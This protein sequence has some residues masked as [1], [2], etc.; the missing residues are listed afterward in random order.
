MELKFPNLVIYLIIAIVAS[1]AHRS[2]RISSPEFHGE[3][4][5]ALAKYVISIRSRTPQTFFGD[6]HYCCGGLISPRWALTAAHCVM[7][8]L[9]VM[10]MPR[11]LLVVAGTPQRLRYVHGKTVCTPVESLHVPKEFIMFNQMNMALIRLKNALPMN[12]P[13]IGFLLLPLGPPNYGDIYSVL[14]WG[15]MYMGGPLASEILQV[16]VALMHTYNCLSYFRYFRKGMLCAGKDNTTLDADPCP[17]DIGSPLIRNRVMV[18]IVAYPLGCGSDT[19]PTVYTDVYVGLKWIIETV[20]TAS[21]VGRGPIH[22]MV[23]SLL[24]V[25][26]AL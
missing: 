16:N 23:M 15:R 22:V 10:H 2:K 12:N 5:W 13:N 9:K 20:Y 19:L 24:V 14:G 4:T 7:D 6:N 8:E 1:E 26:L 18:G 17:G 11:M 21:V 3:T 25:V